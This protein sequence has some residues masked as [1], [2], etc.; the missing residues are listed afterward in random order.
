MMSEPA[1]GFLDCPKAGHYKHVTVCALQCPYKFAPKCPAFQKYP[2][3]DVDRHLLEYQRKMKERNMSKESEIK[4]KY[5]EHEEVQFMYMS[6]NGMMFF[7]K[8]PMA[9]L[10]PKHREAWERGDAKVYRIAAELEL[11]PQEEEKAVDDSPVADKDIKSP[12]K[13]KPKRKKGKQRV[14]AKSNPTAEAEKSTKEAASSGGPDGGGGSSDSVAE[15]SDKG[16]EGKTR[17]KE[18]RGTTRAK[19]GRKTA[20]KASEEKSAPEKK[21]GSFFQ[22][23]RR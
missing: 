20:E 3:E 23:L 5:I 10:P 11:Q 21:K 8:D 19:T 12:Q 9:F 22:R 2:S 1:D 14:Q 18:G 17:A 7:R 6:M 4:K 15:G 16:S 13:T